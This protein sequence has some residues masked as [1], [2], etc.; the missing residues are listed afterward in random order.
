MKKST[1]VVLGATSFLGN[2][3]IINNKKLHIKAVSRKPLNKFNF[4]NSNIDFFECDLSISN[5]LDD[6]LDPG[7]V[8]INFIY[9]AKLNLKKNIIIQRNILNSCAKKKVSK[10][11]YIS[12][13]AVYGS[14]PEMKITE[15]SVCLPKTT[16]EI[17]KFTLEKYITKVRHKKNF[18][19]VILRPSGVI[20]KHILYNMVGKNYF[21]SLLKLFLFYKRP[22]YLIHVNTLISAILFF[23]NRN[24]FYKS[25]I[26]NLV[27]D[28]DQ[29]NYY[30]I[31]AFFY[32]QSVKKVFFHFPQFFL[33][34]L[35]FFRKSSFW[36]LNRKFSSYKIKSEGFNSFLS[37]FS[38]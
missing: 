24:V 5:V 26:F 13:I 34:I 17:N 14:A 8:V 18:N 23:I 37:I 1:I 10:I 28:D 6:I 20:N 16:Y 38:D 7:D 29:D 3:F 32:P 19:L 31:F 4:N 33:V 22:M 11:I 9:N 2:S 12:S 36:N 27:S 35:L 21:E 15:K 25:E 30:N